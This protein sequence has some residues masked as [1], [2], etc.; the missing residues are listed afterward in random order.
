MADFDTLINLITTTIAPQTWEALGGPGSIEGFP[1]NLSLVISQTQEVH[2]QIADLLDQLRRL[3]DLQ[4]TIEVRFIT[5]ND[6]FFERIG[7]DFDFNIED[8]SGQI[9]GQNPIIRDRNRSTSFGL[10]PTGAPTVDFDYQFRQGSFGSRCRSSAGSMP[11][12]QP[13]SASPSSA[14]SR[15]SSCC[16]P[17]RETTGPTCCRRPR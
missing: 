3:Q 16:K 10:D 11:R 15:S 6:R 8:N 12:P 14:T 2:E 5:L 17:L 1:T 7:I 13:I 4:V 9:A